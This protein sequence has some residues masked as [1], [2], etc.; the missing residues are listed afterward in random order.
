MRQFL[1]DISEK[2]R[3]QWE[4]DYCIE[5]Q[6]Y[7]ARNC[8]LEIN[9]ED[10]DKNISS[11]T[12]SDSIA[13]RN[14]YGFSKKKEIKTET[15]VSQEESKPKSLYVIKHGD[16]EFTECPVPVI[17]EGLMSSEDRF[18]NFII[19][20][21]NWSEATGNMP[22]VGGLLDQSNLYYESRVIILAEQNKIEHEKHEEIKNKA[23]KE[24]K[25]KS[26]SKSPRRR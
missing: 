9:K 5:R 21:V 15:Q 2:A 10:E 1:A 20:I 6:L 16:F 3:E 24:S 18:A 8:P 22:V 12:V 11:E 19:N 17:T 25:S 4:C 14:K 26:L 13:A 7:T 23:D